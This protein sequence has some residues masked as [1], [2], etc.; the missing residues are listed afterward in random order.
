[1]TAASESLEH[2]FG[3][4]RAAEVSQ[5]VQRHLEVAL[6]GRAVIE[7]AKGA[8]MFA[9]G[10]DADEAFDLLRRHSQRHNVRVRDLAARLVTELTAGGG[11]A[12]RTGEPVGE[13]LH[14]AAARRLLAATRTRWGV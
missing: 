10:V 7:Q 2:T 3:D 11:A 12:T 1:M 13:L 14:D 9:Y 4:A 5:E 6:S 8:L